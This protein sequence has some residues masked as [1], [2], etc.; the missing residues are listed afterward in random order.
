[1][2]QEITGWEK[3]TNEELESKHEYYERIKYEFGME[4]AKD[5]MDLKKEMRKRDIY[6]KPDFCW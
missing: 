4:A 1:M 2:E 3:Y 5:F 6:V